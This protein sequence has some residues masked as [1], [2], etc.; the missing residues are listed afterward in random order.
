MSRT[1]EST[2]LLRHDESAAFQPVAGGIVFNTDQ[3]SC[4]ASG[5]LF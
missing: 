1:I 3:Y 5:M 2:A 4:I